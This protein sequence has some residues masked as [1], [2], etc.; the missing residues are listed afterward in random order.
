VSIFGHLKTKQENAEKPDEIEAQ[1][2]EQEEMIEGVEN[3]SETT[4]K[5]AVQKA[6]L[7]NV[8]SH[9]TLIIPGYAAPL[10]GKIEDATGWKVLVGPRDA[11]EVGEFL[12]K[13]WHS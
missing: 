11:A 13:E 5:E 4:V 8:V 10:S 6:G 1:D 12:E 9:R 3:L 2:T 7:E